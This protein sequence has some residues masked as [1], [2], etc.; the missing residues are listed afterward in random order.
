MPNPTPGTPGRRERKRQQQL[1]HLADTAWA[2]FQA[3]GFESV[4]ME[5][6]AAAADVAKGTLYKHFPMKAALLRHRFHRELLTA[7][8]TIQAKL[9]ALA[10]G[11]AR[12]ARFLD[13]QVAWFEAR[14]AFLQPYMGLR[15]SGA[16]LFDPARERSGL[17]AILDALIAQAQAAGEFRRDLPAP[18][19]AM[20]LQFAQLATLLRW[21][22]DDGL[23]LADETARMFDLL[24]AGMEAPR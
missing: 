9:A 7:W 11:K 24:C 8:P 19:L 12:L 6:I 5:A 20:H 1:D 10:P 21:L 16:D 14:R 15:L 17:G 13:L 22:A 3:E 2:L 18:L 23:S 4:T